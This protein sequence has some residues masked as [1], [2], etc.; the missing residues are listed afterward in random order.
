MKPLLTLLFCSALLLG[1]T[2]ALH[3]RPTFKGYACQT[4]D[5]AGH[6][7]GY[8]WAANNNITRPQACYDA[9]LKSQ[10]FGEGCMA[11]VEGN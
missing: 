5:C 4:S 2:S 1:Q 9:M 7:A 6:K 11:Y 10:A 8:R 3:A